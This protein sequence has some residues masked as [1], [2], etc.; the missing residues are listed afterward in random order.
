MFAIGEDGAVQKRFSW[1]CILHE[2]LL[3]VSVWV[4]KFMNIELIL[5]AGNPPAI[6]QGSRFASISVASSRSLARSLALAARLLKTGNRMVQIAGQMCTWA[7]RVQR[8]GQMV[9]MEFSAVE[10]AARL[11]SSVYDALGTGR[12][13]LGCEHVV[14]KAKAADQ[15]PEEVRRF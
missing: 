9:P 10:P 8:E 2:C 1:F 4:S 11:S 12:A 3:Y 13:L 5:L 6:W 15:R 14:A 7:S